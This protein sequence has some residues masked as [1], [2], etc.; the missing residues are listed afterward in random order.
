MTRVTVFLTNQSCSRSRKYYEIRFI[1]QRGNIIQMHDIQ[2]DGET[3]PQHSVETQH[4]DTFCFY[5][6]NTQGCQYIWQI[7]SPTFPGFPEE[8][9]VI[10]RTFCAEIRNVVSKTSEVNKNSKGF[11]HFWSCL[12]SFWDNLG[13]FSQE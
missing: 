1:M 12:K 7:L 9:L 3:D 4:R 6:Y 11:G 10:S 2:W 8:Y 13:T 5:D